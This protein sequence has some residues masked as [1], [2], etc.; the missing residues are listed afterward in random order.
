MWH[1]HDSVNKKVVSLHPHKGISWTEYK[2]QLEIN[3]ITCINY[4]HNN[5][6]NNK[7]L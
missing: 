3:R 4:N 6:H 2:K 1:H 7:R 5:N